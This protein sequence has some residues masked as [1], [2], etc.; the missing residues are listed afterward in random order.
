MKKISARKLLLD[1][2]P[3]DAPP[4]V[5]LPVVPPGLVR[6]GWD[7]LRKRGFWLPPAEVRWGG[8]PGDQHPHGWLVAQY[9]YALSVD[10][11]RVRHHFWSTR[12]GW[13]AASRPVGLLD[14]VKAL[15]GRIAFDAGGVEHCAYIEFDFDEGHRV[16]HEELREAAEDPQFLAQALRLGNNAGVLDALQVALAGPCLRRTD[17]MRLYVAQRVRAR[18]EGLVRL[19]PNVSWFAWSTPGGCR[20]LALLADAFPADEAEALARSVATRARLGCET[21]PRR[22]GS[23][24]RLPLMGA[25]ARALDPTL[26]FPRFRDRWDDVR[27]LVSL[28]PASLADF[29]LD[30][31][32]LRRPAPRRAAALGKPAADYVSPA[33]SPLSDQ[34]AIDWP[35]CLSQQLR[36]RAYENAMVRLLRSGIPDDASFPAMQKLAFLFHVQCGLPVGECEQMLC[37]FLKRTGHEATH[38]QSERGLRQLQRGFRST[39]QHLDKGKLRAGGLR[40]GEALDEVNRVRA[41]A[42]LPAYTPGRRRKRN[43]TVVAHV[44]P[45]DHD[46]VRKRLREAKKRRSDHAQHAAR[47][48][49]SRPDDDTFITNQRIQETSG[50]SK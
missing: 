24:G 27:A 29:G 40:R 7:A 14:Y 22:S 10:G 13:L 45:D 9:A 48:R 38:C 8:V 26:R 15:S 30:R 3:F 49:H 47:V 25:A 5:G 44:D 2:P 35:R 21:F 50:N 33:P 11:L 28:K 16:R 19:F 46:P 43:R 20:V 23:Y 1:G 17:L 6:D 18:F 36:G 41:E 39:L 12:R 34:G 37:A 32:D 4:W 31:K 42:N